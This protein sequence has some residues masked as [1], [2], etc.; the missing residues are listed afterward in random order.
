MSPVFSVAPRGDPALQP[1][2]LEIWRELRA[3]LE[4]QVWESNM[5]AGEPLW[6]TAAS[7]APAPRMAVRSTAWPADY[8]ELRFDPDRAVLQC[9]F[10]PAVRRRD[11]EFRLVPGTPAR[12]RCGETDRSAQETV[13]FVLDALIPNED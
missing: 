5:L 2:G 10:G 6:T 8:L 7:D 13:L 4:T 9:T 12:L 1:A 3:L 11:C